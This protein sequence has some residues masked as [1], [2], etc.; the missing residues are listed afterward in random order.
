M[1][2]SNQQENL[3]I[4]YNG[5]SPPDTETSC[6]NIQSNKFLTKKAVDGDEST[7]I[8]PNVHNN[9]GRYH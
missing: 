8:N 6:L 3:R 5:G 4:L 2:G 1:C 9:Y 7:T